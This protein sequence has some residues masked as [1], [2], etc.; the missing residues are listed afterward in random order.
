MSG[1]WSADVEKRKHQDTV[2]RCGTV[3]LD[4]GRVL[5]LLGVTPILRSARDYRKHLTLRG[6]IAGLIPVTQG[7][8][9][10]DGVWFP[11]EHSH[12]RT[13]RRE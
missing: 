1:Y 8:L 2:P 5:S 12:C 10:N 11:Y 3:C 7:E 13:F 9:F 4:L 6:A